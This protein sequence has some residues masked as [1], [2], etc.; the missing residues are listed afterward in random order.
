LVSRYGGSCDN[1][2]DAEFLLVDLAE[3]LIKAKTRGYDKV[4]LHAHLMYDDD[5]EFELIGA[6]LETSQEVVARLAH[7]EQ[8]LKNHAV[9]TLQHEAA[10]LTREEVLAAW[11][12]GQKK[13]EG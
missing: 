6:R 10:A 5:V 8:A 13:K 1:A 12:A 9:Y 3:Q 4:V 11:E 7:K 2:L